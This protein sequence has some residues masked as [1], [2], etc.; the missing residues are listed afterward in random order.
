MFL[1][2]GIY[3]DK[4]C[5]DGKRLCANHIRTGSYAKNEIW[6]YKANNPPTSCVLMSNVEK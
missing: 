1:K 3:R 5:P 6:K 2:A 4:P